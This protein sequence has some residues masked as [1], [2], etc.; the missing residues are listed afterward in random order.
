MANEVGN[1][2]VLGSTGSIGQSTLEV[3]RANREKFRVVGLAAGRDVKAIAEQVAEFSPLVVSLADETAGRELAQIVGGKCKVVYG[4]RAAEEVACHSNVQTVVAG[5]VGFAGLRTVLAALEAGKHVALANK[6]AL[7]AAGELVM[8]RARQSGGMLMPVDSEHSSVFQ[9]L[10]VRQKKDP[11]RRIILTA[12]GGPFL[13]LEQNELQGVTVADAVRHPRWQMG[14][15]I[16]VDSAT[17]M[18]KGLEVIEARW[19]FDLPPEQIDVLVHPQSVVHGMAEF[20][21]GTSVAVMYEASMQI[22]IAYALA[23]LRSESPESEPGPRIASAGVPFLNLA[24]WG[25]LE[26][27]EVDDLRFP[28]LRLCYEALKAGGLFPAVLN[29]ANECAV[30]SFLREQIAFCDIVPIVRDVLGRY[31]GESDNDLD[32]IVLVD[33]WARNCASELISKAA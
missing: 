29:A 10:L 24:K 27:S 12:S 25:N 2:A 16:S 1:I 13:K 14:A 4:K 31:T 3:V 9:C 28:A 20:S 32:N 18:N 8:E 21:D 11:L 7:V 6:E 5:I 33:A 23:Y 30:Q 17:L 15:K 22:P 26:F 19:L